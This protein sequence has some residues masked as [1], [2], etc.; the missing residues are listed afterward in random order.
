MPR[1]TPGQEVLLFLEDDPEGEEGM[2]YTVGMAQ[3]YFHVT[4]DPETG[5][6]S[7]EQQLGGVTLAAPGPTGQI[8]PVHGVRPI[9]LEIEELVER[10]QQARQAAPEGGGE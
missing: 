3:G 4:T 1:F 7:A 5:V 6:K 9:V 2:Y 8:A 10:I